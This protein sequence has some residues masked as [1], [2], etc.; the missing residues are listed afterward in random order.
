MNA[1]SMVLI[2][3]TKVSGLVRFFSCTVDAIG[4]AIKGYMLRNSA[5][6]LLEI[7]FTQTLGGRRQRENVV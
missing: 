1:D 4:Q 6:P 2:I 5:L 7:L 3:E